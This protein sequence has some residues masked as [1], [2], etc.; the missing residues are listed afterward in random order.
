[1]PVRPPRAP[2]E[3]A[4]PSS[5]PGVPP[6]GRLVIVKLW[7]QN[8]FGTFGL[9]DERLTR[10]LVD[11]PRVACVLH[12]EPP[13]AREALDEAP[14]G[15]RERD[16]LLE[17]TRARARGVIDGK[18]RLFT[19]A[20][21]RTERDP[22]ASVLPQVARACAD[23]G[24]FAGP[25]LLWASAPGVLADRVVASFGERFTWLL[26][27]VEDDHR[28]YAAPRSE[29]RLALQRRYE[30]LVRAS[31]LLISNSP[32]M[33]AEW[34]RLQPVAHCIRNAVD[35]SAYAT[36]APEPE[37][38]AALGRPRI[39]YAGN[40]RLRLRPELL[41][42][43]AR[44]FP[45]ATVLLAG[46]GGEEL[47]AALRR[48]DER[49]LANVHWIGARPY[50]EV[51][52]LLQH[53]DVL[54]VPHQE[55][56]LTEGM[57][58]QKIF[59]YLASGRPIVSTPVAGAREHDG[60]LRL[61]RSE[62]E[63]VAAVGA[64]LAEDDAAAAARRRALGTQRT[65]HDAARAVVDAALRVGEP[66][67][68]RRLE[69]RVAYF[70][71][72]RPEV[73]ALVP[74]LATRVLD[75]GCGAGLLGGALRFRRGAR[76]TGIEIDRTA[77]ARAGEELDDVRVGDAL[78]CMRSLPAANF[79]AVVF[80]DVLEHLA[81]P[82]EALVQAR[83]LLAPGGVVVASL[84]NVR[85]WSVVR[86][87]LAGEF[88]YEAAGILDR[89]HLRFFTRASARRLFAESGF[90]VGH[91]EGTRWAEDGA[92]HEVVAALER[93]GV[94]VRGFAEESRDH[95]LLFVARPA[96]VV[97]A[98]APAAVAAAPRASVV[99][100][101]CNAVDYTRA[102]LDE[103]ARRGAGLEVVVVD[104]GSSDG[105]RELLAGRPHVRTI[106]NEENRGFAGAVN[107]GLA[108]ATAPLVCVLNNDTLLTDGWLEPL[109]ARLEAD[110]R[111][112]LVGPCTSYAK[113][114]QQ[115]DLTGGERPLRDLDDM[116][117]LA[118][119]WCERERGKS[120]DV[121]FLSGFCFVARRA[122]LLP[123][124]G[125]ASEYGRGT[126]EDDELCRRLR[127]AGR[128]LVI[129]RDAFV[130]HFGNRTFQ[131]L[132]VD[133]QR[134]Q[135][136]NWKTFAARH[137]GDAALLARAAA[138]SNRWGDVLKLAV[139]ALRAAP[140]DLDALWF[141]ALATARLGRPQE[142]VKLLDHYLARCP[143]DP[144]AK[145]LRSGSEALSGSPPAARN[146]V[147]G[148][149]PDGSRDVV[150]TA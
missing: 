86:Q 82:E 132:G 45:Q 80:A 50:S 108:A 67:A 78:A 5:G 36:P 17:R 14:R 88:R 84:P 48:I 96:A 110:P 119:R 24:A 7:Y 46:T 118:A 19:P 75:V 93:A 42:A 129:A 10:A 52:A 35:A 99:I 89:T 26:T 148:A 57:D 13:V 2:P 112:A 38:I 25:S 146:A 91:A 44:A 143:D 120:E 79:D 20:V 1:M 30:R 104:N 62:A 85:H 34:S 137:S 100:P 49:A 95:Q 111:V 3:R 9:R 124:G 64:A 31:D 121:A 81:A 83:R 115:V 90:E 87:L 33:V 77:A 138:E 74:P 68:R 41:I 113:G 147:P 117:E 22:W 56:A 134:Q 66:G 55:G 140:A 114:R 145:S 27:E 69:K 131:A 107:Q 130:W 23:A 150:V 54:I 72:D 98:S 149:A 122:D 103:L 37:S 21:A 65:W 18:L 12:V 58:P 71:H 116:R 8:D 94:D 28:E 123:L 59:E 16:A 97:A 135:A 61:A 73:R 47:L 70:Q 53:S 11:D 6:S 144:L 127:R 105:T 126:F 125:L 39:T 29:E 133:L 92:P 40:L 101:V 102:C 142:A 139:T 32:A 136:E 51:P 109:I 76:V 63:F 43:V 4:E 141:S 60:A 106:R 15:D 128:R